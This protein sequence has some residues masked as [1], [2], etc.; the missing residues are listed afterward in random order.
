MPSSWLL[1]VLSLLD[2]LIPLV[3]PSPM[4]YMHIQPMPI[5]HP[6][7]C[8][9]T[10]TH[11]SFSFVSLLLC[12]FSHL[13]CNC[14]ACIQCHNISTNLLWI[15]INQS[16]FAIYVYCVPIPSIHPFHYSIA[17]AVALPVIHLNLHVSISIIISCEQFDRSEV[18]LFFVGSL[19]SLAHYTIHSST[20]HRNSYLYSSYI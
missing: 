7:L 14:H 12:S 17:I 15:Y 18:D 11:V 9:D 6:S 3:L 4:H 1:S 13:L 2:P 19:S 20:I 10:W 16:P 8:H 5:H